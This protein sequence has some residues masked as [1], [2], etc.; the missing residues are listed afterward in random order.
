MGDTSAWRWQTPC[1]AAGLSIVILEQSATFSRGKT[2]TTAQVRDHLERFGAELRCAA[3]PLPLSRTGLTMS[4]VIRRYWPQGSVQT[5][6]W[7]RKPGLRWPRR[8]H[9]GGR[10]TETNLA[11]VYAAG[12]CAERIIPFWT[13]PLSSPRNYC[14]QNGKGGRRQCSGTA[15]TIRRSGRYLHCGG[16]RGSL[17]HHRDFREQARREG[18]APAVARIEGLSRASY[19][20]GRPTQSNWWRTAPH[21]VRWEQP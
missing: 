11:G 16:V 8:R 19:L 12:D 3:R 9:T 2:R 1:G 6:K 13:G 17:C 20:G 10:S 14:Q 7:R 18:F 5:W 4:G 21:G 15:R